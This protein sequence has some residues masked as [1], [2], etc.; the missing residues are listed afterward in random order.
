MQVRL[1]PFPA[2]SAGVVSSWATTAEE[3]LMWCSH[4]VAP[5]PADQIN[6]W[7]Q[8]DGVQAFGLYRDGRL[9]G[10]GELWVDDGEAE[11]ELAR[12]IVDPAERG[13]GLGRRMVTGLAGLARA[14]YPRVFVRVRTTSPHSAVTLRRALTPSSRVRRPSGTLASRSATSGSAPYPVAQ[15]FTRSPGGWASIRSATAGR[16]RRGYAACLAWCRAG[17]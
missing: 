1:H 17:R 12:L 8:E 3:A 14:R 13:Q 9:V 6:A 7:A 5:V 15:R 4:P 2:D 11:V 16:S 10:S